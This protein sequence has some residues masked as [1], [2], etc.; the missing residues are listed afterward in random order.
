MRGISEEIM[1]EIQMRRATIQRVVEETR[2]AFPEVRFVFTQS[3]LDKL[4]DAMR[5][6]DTEA[7]IRLLPEL[8]R[9]SER[10]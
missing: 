8:R 5:L 6:D 9:L 4:D 1:D 10:G 7:L 3:M 2:V